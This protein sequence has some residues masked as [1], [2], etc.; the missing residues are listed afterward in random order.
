MWNLA[1]KLLLHDRPRFAVAIAGVSVSVMLVLVQVG[2]YFGFMD[3]AS[4]IIDASH[5]DL[6][7]GKKGNE[8][9]EFATPFDERT[10]YKVASVQGVERTERV[11]M[12]FAQFKLADGGDLGVQIVGV[13]TTPGYAPLLGPWNLVAGDVNRLREAG[14]IVVDRSE[15]KKLGIDKV[16]HVT[17]VNS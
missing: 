11:L 17:E 14:A 15:Y 5:A 4:S 13:E 6:W 10:F 9:F 2:L 7:V 16:D 8:S 3:T 12:N 1:R